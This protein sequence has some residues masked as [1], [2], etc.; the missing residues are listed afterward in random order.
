MM[1]T[2]VRRKVLGIQMEHP[3]PAFDIAFLGLV[4]GSFA[5]FA[6]VLGITS[7]RSS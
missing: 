5:V 4:V 3:M 6:V 2:T 7:W 1:G